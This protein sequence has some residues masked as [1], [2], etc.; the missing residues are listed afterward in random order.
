[1]DYRKE[2]GEKLISAEKAAS[3]VNSG[4][5]VDYAWAGQTPVSIDRELAKRAGELENVV[6]RGGVLLGVPEIFKADPNGDSFIWFS[7]HSGGADRGRINSTDAAFYSPLRY[8]EL[9]RWYRENSRVDVA[10]IVVAPMNKH[11][12][13]N[14]GLNAS[15]LMAVVETAKKV[16]VEVNE[17]LPIALGGF[18]NEVHISDV[19][20]IVEGENPEMLELP[21]GSFGEVDKKVAEL[22]VAEI[23][24]GACIQLGIGGMPNAVGSLIAESDLKDLGVHTE[25]FVDAFVDLYNRG[26]ITGAKKNIDRFRQTYAF[27]AGTKKLYDFIDNNPQCMSAP[28]DYTNDSR[29]ISKLDNFVSINNAVN[30]DLVGQ[31]SSESSGYKHISG[32]GGQLDFVL[33]S[34]LAEGGKSFVC[35]SSTFFNKK[36]NKE[37]SR[38][39]PNFEMGS[40][41]TVPRPVTNYLVTEH[42]IFNAKGKSTWERA[43]G[44]IN[45]AAPQFRDELISEAEKMGIWRK[46]N[47]K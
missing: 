15:H 3:F 11:G 23:P 22:I 35:L 36:T 32:A 14:M 10:Y 27:A 25:M 40:A 46:S 24:N 43:E 30:I 29:I 5:Y 17:N 47:R 12:Y 19:D 21:A 41:I 26:K 1:M 45:I 9:P 33:G 28:V 13:F 38:I 31:V 4:D 2:Y 42:G 16:V 6:V 39:V 44:I 37:E 20:F 8:S 7:W 34:Y 18:E